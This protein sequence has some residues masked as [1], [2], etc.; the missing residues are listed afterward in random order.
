MAWLRRLWNA[1]QPGRM[2]RELDRELAFHVRERAEDL[3]GRG[4]SETEAWR[5]ARRAFGNFTAQVERTRDMDVNLFADALGRNLRGALR[6]LR[7]SPGFAVA[8][9]VTLALGM[10]A[11]TAVFSAIYAVVLRPLPF[12]EGDRLVSIEQINPRAGIHQVAPVRLEEWN[13]LNTTFSAI[14]GYYTEDESETSGELPEKLTRA[15]VAPRFLAVWGIAPQRGRDFAEAEEHFGGPNAVLISDRLWRRRFNADPRVVGKRLRLGRSSVPIIGVLPANF[16]FPDRGIDLWSTSPPDAPFAQ[17]RDATWFTAFGRLRPGVTVQQAGANLAAVQASLARQFPDPDAKL[18]TAV[19]ALKETAVGPVRRSLWMLYGSVSLLLLIA[20][21]NVAALL[22][23]RAAARRHEIAVRFSLGASRGAVAAQLL[24]EVLVLAVAGSA[25]GLA[26]A[27]LASHAFQRLAKDLPRVEEIGLDG[28][29]VAYTFGCAMIVTLVCGLF[30]A[31]RWT[32]R[33]PAGPLAGAGRSAVAGR[34]AIQMALV[35]VQVALAVT[36]LAGAGLLVRSFRELGRVSPGFDAERVLT[37]S[38][39]SSWGETVDG[40]ASQRRVDRILEGVRALPGV[41]AAAS[42]LTLPG[43]PLAYEVPL[44]TAEGR[45]ESEP[46]MIAQSRLVTPSY[47]ATMRI[48]LLA[49]E[50]CRDDEGAS[51]MMVNRSFANAYLGGAAAVGRHLGQVGNAYLPVSRVAGIVGDAR[52]T[53]MDRA[54][55][56]TVYWCFGATQPGTYFLVRTKGDPAA[57]TETV[58]RRVHELEPLRSVY[59]MEPL[60]ERLAGAYSGNRMRTVLLAF[61]AMT[62]IT[63][64]CVGLYGTLSYVVNV[65]RREVGVRLALGA[66]RSRIVRQFLGQGIRVALAGCAA[67]L[68]LATASGRL[69]AGMLYGVSPSDALTLGGV[70]ATVMAVCVAASLA[71][72]I[73]ASRVEPMKVLREE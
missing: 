36:L 31:I 65:R 3:R 66:E 8:V 62:A 32:R 72:A 69:L 35:T 71:P 29:I 59:G 5:E 30:P 15:L 40:K 57:M 39:S 26:V 4:M 42:S 17:R 47:F 22:L 70:A 23:S 54:P 51:S 34:N 13:R 19:M 49:G 64:A 27:A 37:F 73:R 48:P 28:R 21:A 12:P 43:V 20:C 11:N 61:F 14:S 16:L 7:K 41:A 58:R 25:L 63:L 55:G 60:T 44:T 46:R 53:G 52:E 56:P 18:G 38:V 45:A 10:G 6:G 33:D 1:A 67:G 9:I 24:T 2:Q 68:L 50:V